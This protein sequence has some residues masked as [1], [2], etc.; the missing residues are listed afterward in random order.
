MNVEIRTEA[1]Q[2]PEKEYINV[3]FSL[4]CGYKDRK[5]VL[6]EP[7][8]ESRVEY[9]RKQ[10]IE[11]RIMGCKGNLSIQEKIASFVFQS[12]GEKSF[13]IRSGRRF[14]RCQLVLVQ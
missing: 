8:S 10:S 2:S 14:W 7:L 3:F 5:E 1:T 6:A 4:Q 13:A 9:W 12:K 11:G